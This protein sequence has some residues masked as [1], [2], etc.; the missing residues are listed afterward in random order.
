MYCQRNFEKVDY[1]MII[2][3]DEKYT[4]YYS[5][6]ELQNRLNVLCKK[7]ILKKVYVSLLSY[8]ESLSRDKN[9][10]SFSYLGGPVILIFDNTAI[11][12]CVHGIGM[13]QCREM[14]L[15]DVKIRN[16]KDAQPFDLDLFDDKYF[17][18]LGKE[19]ELQ[20][21]EQQVTEV[22]VDRIDYYPFDLTGFDEEKARVAEQTNCLPNHIYFKLDN[23]VVFGVCADEIEYF[24][25][26]LEN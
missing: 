5:Y 10:Y 2:T 12:L 4:W 7:H 20:Y 24:Y 21:E 13:I 26:E 25:I 6:L 15:W 19:F 18:D 8:L 11:E 9:Y 17:Y 16:I 1:S 22:I 23:G 14:N 3:P